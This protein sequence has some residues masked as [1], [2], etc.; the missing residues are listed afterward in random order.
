MKPVF[1]ITLLLVCTRLVAQSVDNPYRT[2]YLGNSNNLHWTD[3]LKW[4]NVVSVTSNGA[5][6]GDGQSDQAAVQQTINTVASQGGGVVYFP[7]G[8]YN[9]TD[10]LLVK[11]GVVLR[12]FTPLITSALDTNYRP[13][14]ILEFPEFVF[15]S[16]ANGGT[17]NNVKNAFKCIV[18]E[19]NAHDIGLVNLDI[20][21]ARIIFQPWQWQL[22]SNLRATTYYP[23]DTVYNVLIMGVRSNNTAAPSPNI[24]DATQKPW[25]QFSWRF[26]SNISVFVSHNAI[27]NNNR[28]NDNVTDSYN[29]PG[30]VTKTRSGITCQVFPADGSGAAFSYTNHYGI[31]LNRCKLKRSGPATNASATGSLSGLGVY[32]SIPLA[33]PQ[34]EPSLFAPGNEVIGNWIFKTMRV[35]IWAAGM[36]LKIENNTMRDKSGKRQYL[37]PDG[38]GCLQPTGPTFEHRGIDFSGWKCRIVNNDIEVNQGFYQIGSGNVYGTTDGEGILLQELGGGTA[39]NDYVISGNTIKA[40]NGLVSLYKIGDI[41][42]VTVKNNIYVGAGL[43]QF[44]FSADRNGAP[45]Y[46]VNNLLVD[47]NYNVNEI[48]ITGSKGGTPSYV[49]NNLGTGNAPIKVPCH[50]ILSNNTGFAAPVLNNTP[51]PTAIVPMARIVQPG[52][53]TSY[54]ISPGNTPYTIRVKQVNGSVSNSR[55]VLYQGITKLDS[56]QIA[57]TDSTYSFVVNSMQNPGTNYYTVTLTDLTQNILVYSQTIAVQ[58]KALVSVRPEF[59]H[60]GLLTYPNPGTAFIVVEGLASTDALQITDALGRNMAVTRIAGNKVQL[61]GYTPGIYII[62]AIGLNGSVR[63]SRFVVGN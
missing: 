62:K 16:L 59:G 11:T 17:G 33:Q 54:L 1:F 53:D 15:D 47:S 51:C 20:N 39:A 46:Y 41:N 38:L 23:I 12:G 31:S 3:T 5:I 26:A 7:A 27:I 49:T 58:G 55:V 45:N 24:P 48:K 28:L 56:G 44:E 21:R 52:S 37:S 57:A 29:Q 25:Q 4:A 61:N 6:P 10:S 22:K 8:T 40:T 2:Q 63:S 32:P 30:Y 42:N 50:I 34:E 60:S 43:H 35:G 18:Q 19:E 9:F 13:A 14:S 36:G